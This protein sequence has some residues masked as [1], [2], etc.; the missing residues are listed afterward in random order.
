MEVL[1]SIPEQTMYEIKSVGRIMDWEW[2]Y[3]SIE[4]REEV[5]DRLIYSI[6]ETLVTLLLKKIKPW[7]EY[8]NVQQ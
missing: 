4:A 6:K 2:G 7:Q 8:R 3:P 1:L 5:L